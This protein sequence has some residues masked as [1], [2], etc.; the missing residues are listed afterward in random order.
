MKERLTALVL[1]C[2][3]LLLFWALV[4]PK[5]APPDEAEA[6]PL[7]FEAA[8]G[9]YAAAARWLAAEGVRVVSLRHRFDR[10]ADA[11]LAARATGNLLVL[12]LPEEIAV[13]GS[14]LDALERWVRAGNTLL[15]VA[16]LDDTP[17]WSV[18]SAGDM[19]ARLQRLAR[20][21]FEP[22]HEENVAESLG[23]ALRTE[24]PEL[25]AAGSHPLVAGVTR[26]ATRGDL[27]STRWR[28]QP[29]DSAP[30]LVLARRADTGQPAA[31]LRPLGAG[32]II[33]SAWASPFANDRLG[34]R[35]NAQWLARIVAW[36]VGQGGTVIFDDH[37]QGATAYYD[38]QRFYADPRLH[39][40]LW[41]IAALWFVYVL[42][43]RPLLAE[44]TPRPPLDDT[45][46]LRL[47]G[48]FLAHVLR[49]ADAARQLFARFF[50]AL[51]RR[52]S[53]PENGEPLWDWIAAQARV[54]AALLER[55]RQAHARA[56][57][58]RRVDLVRLRNSLLEL[59]ERLS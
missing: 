17:R 24:A 54:D 26:I 50:D 14:E 2:A 6:R 31:W 20:I 3:A 4:F 22:L 55:L 47:S 35:D 59:T 48:G 9:G 13:R 11:E 32:S 8:P 21:G 28:A 33:V 25:Q 29:L 45:S 18:R 58:G 16:A 39:H 12:T 1:A 41:W 51:R 44:P 36:S 43:M 46:M 30:V 38:P 15:L 5:P 56:A 52:L 49:P 7:S 10:L 57:R 53:L 34:E 37:H 23:R 40:T 42:G 27:P 19:P